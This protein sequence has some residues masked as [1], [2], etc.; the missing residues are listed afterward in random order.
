MSDGTRR[1]DTLNHLNVDDD[2]I[3]S[4]AASI[5]LHGYSEEGGR[6]CAVGGVTALC[7]VVVHIIDRNFLAARATLVHSVLHLSLP[8]VVDEMVVSR[9]AGARVVRSW[10]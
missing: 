8:R 10:F 5:R 3:F 9:R 7:G 1:G 4:L 6:E 2:V